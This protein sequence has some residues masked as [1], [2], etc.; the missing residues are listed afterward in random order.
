MKLDFVSFNRF[1]ASGFKRELLNPFK[2][3]KCFPFCRFRMLTRT[4]SV[5]AQVFLLLSIVLVIAIAVIQINQQQVLSPGL[6]VSLRIL[7]KE[8]NVLNRY[9]I[10]CLSKLIF[11]G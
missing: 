3:P 10:M 5:V 1:R 6:K 4:P 7:R 9:L 2:F 8:N 11:M